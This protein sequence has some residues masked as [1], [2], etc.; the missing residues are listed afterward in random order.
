MI[1][2][3]TNVLVRYLVQDDAAQARIAF[4]H[5]DLRSVLAGEQGVRGSEAG[6]AATDDR[7]PLPGAHA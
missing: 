2:I 7:D 4:E 1:A 6:D 5:D 3:D